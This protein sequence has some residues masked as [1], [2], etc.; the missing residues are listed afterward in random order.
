M[1][2]SFF[3]KEQKWFDQWDNYLQ[4]TERGLYNQYSNWI[5]A[6][7]VYGFESILYVITNNNEIVGGCGIVIAK[8][9]FFKFLI[10]PCG[11]VIEKEYESQI[12]T[13]IQSVKEMCIRDRFI[14][15]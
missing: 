10:V 2:A 14:E 4:T 12:D 13:T 11:P 7:D 1:I 9:A 6:Y 3:T 5:K 15:L 8:A